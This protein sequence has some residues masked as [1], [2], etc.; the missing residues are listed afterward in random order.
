M[1]VRFVLDTSEDSLCWRIEPQALGCGTLQ[2][3]V[4]NLSIQSPFAYDY[5]QNQAVDISQKRSKNAPNKK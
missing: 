3:Q 2:T 1:I 4:F 5:K